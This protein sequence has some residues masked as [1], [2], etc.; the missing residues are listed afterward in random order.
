[1][2]ARDAL[3]TLLRREDL[4]EAQATWVFTDIMAGEVA[5]ELLAALLVALRCKGE[6]VPEI[7]G[8][9]RA[10]RA[11]S[12]RVHVRRAPLVDTCGTGGDGSG[13]FNIS[14]AAALVAAGAGAAVAKH[15][16]RSVSSQSGSADVLEALGVRMDLDAAAVAQGIEAHGIGFLLAANHHPAMRHAAP[17]RRLLATRTIFNIL[18]PLTNPAGATRQVLGVFDSALCAPMAEALRQLGCERA[19][20]VHGAGGLDELSLLGPTRVV[21]LDGSGARAFEVAP[22]QV[23]LAPC[24]LED[25]RG[26]DAAANATAMRALLAGQLHGPIRD[27]VC[28]NAAAALVVSDLAHDLQD[29]LRQA[30]A[31]L[32]DGRAEARLAALSA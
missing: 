1:M 9:A 7:V 6:T 14:T 20:V 21:A 4:P 11:A 3:H 26:G 18:G 25:L 8:A 13:T 5:P 29:G 28:L 24:R 32:D 2:R 30:R 17:V 31:A 19:W 23:G 10:M 15:G 27:A 22:D 12:L 16:G